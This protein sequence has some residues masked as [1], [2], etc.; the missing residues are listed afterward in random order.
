MDGVDDILRFWFDECEPRQ[1][2]VK[3]PHFDARIRH[4][5]E[6]CILQARAGALTSWENSLEGCLALILVLDQFPRNVYRNTAE[7][8]SSDPLAL[9]L[10]MMCLDKGYLTH[11]N[12]RWRH[13][14]LIPMMHSE[15][16]AIQEASL[17]LFARYTNDQIY[18]Y[19]VR[20]RDIIARFG[21]YPHRN[22]ILGRH[23]TEEELAFLQQPGARF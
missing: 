7:A 14:M 22:A 13:F 10:T 18:D 2:F 9:S 4:R 15:D 8:F 1:W 21:R 19:A 23:S 5:F 20:H 12:L 11:P 16:L 17:P 3:D 6:A